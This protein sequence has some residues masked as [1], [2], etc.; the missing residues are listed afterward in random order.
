VVLE[1]LD[2]IDQFPPNFCAVRQYHYIYQLALANWLASDGKGFGDAGS[3]GCR[4]QFQLAVAAGRYY[5][6]VTLLPELDRL[7]C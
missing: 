1:L 4:P 2:P 3:A 7:P 6:C 5:M